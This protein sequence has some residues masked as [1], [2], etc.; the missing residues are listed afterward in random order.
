MREKLK[1]VVEDNG[2]EKSWSTSCTFLL[3]QGGATT[4]IFERS[5][6]CES[7]LEVWKGG[8]HASFVYLR[9]E[10]QVE[11]CAC[12]VSYASWGY[13]GGAVEKTRNTVSSDL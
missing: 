13:D 3:S 10:R 9:R 1:D 2:G 8:H 4:R 7:V 6:K 5:A 11:V 12:E